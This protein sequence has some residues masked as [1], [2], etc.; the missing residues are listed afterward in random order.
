MDFKQLKKDIRKKIVH[1]INLLFYNAITSI[2][3]TFM[4]G[5]TNMSLKCFNHSVN[6]TI[7]QII[8]LSVSFKNQMCIKSTT[9]KKDRAQ[10][11]ILID[12]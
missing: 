8:R 10:R 9:T 3:T 11:K 6:L 1:Y 5:I 4:A 12:E 7:N 2:I